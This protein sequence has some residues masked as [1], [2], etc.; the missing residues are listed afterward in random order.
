MNKI[1]KYKDFLQETKKQ[2]YSVET[3]KKELTKFLSENDMEKISQDLIES[4]EG[5]ADNNKISLSELRDILLSK[6]DEELTTKFFK[7]FKSIK[8]AKEMQLEIP[9]ISR[10]L[11]AA[12]KHKNLKLDITPILAKIQKAINR[13][14]TIDGSKLLKILQDHTSPEQLRK[15]LQYLKLV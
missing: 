14:N 12:N 4:M 7:Q 5:I 3:L 10:L 6:L 13:D 8:E 9:G 1:L 11:H 15:L 2:D